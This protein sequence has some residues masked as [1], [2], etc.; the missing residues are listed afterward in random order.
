[1]KSPFDPSTQDDK[2]IGNAQE[3]F[4]LLVPPFVCTVFKK[5]VSS[6]SKS[7]SEGSTFYRT[8]EYLAE[9]YKIDL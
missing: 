9:D 1:M 4:S 6:A 8:L 3:R 2:P 7:V 5:S